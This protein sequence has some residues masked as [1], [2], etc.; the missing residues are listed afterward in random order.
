MTKFEL[1]SDAQSEQ[2]SGGVYFGANYNLI[3][4]ANVGSAWAVGGE[5]NSLWG[6]SG[7]NANANTTQDNVAELYNV[8]VSLF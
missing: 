7:A 1:L 4:Q 6:T 8:I 5:S 2:V 3:S